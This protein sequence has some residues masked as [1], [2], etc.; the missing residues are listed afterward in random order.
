V[1]AA[2]GAYVRL[3]PGEVRDSVALEGLDEADVISAL[4][5]LVLDFDHY[6]RLIGIRVT[7]SAESVLPPA[8]LE[9]A[10]RS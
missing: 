8:L 1:G 3:G 6:G 5:S 2:G 4:G 9:D 10:L 7:D